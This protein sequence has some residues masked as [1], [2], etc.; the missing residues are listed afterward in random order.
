M[1]AAWGWLS[2]P[3]AD[4][5]CVTLLHFLWQGALCS[6]LGWT[7]IQCFAANSS[8]RRYGVWLT[9]LLLMALLPIATLWWTAPRLGESAHFAVHTDGQWIDATPVLASESSVWMT[10]E[11]DAIADSA[12]FATLPSA[13]DLRRWQPYLLLGWLM[14]VAVTSLRVIFGAVW[15]VRL[16]QNLERWPERWTAIAERLSR[17]LGLRAVPRLGLSHAVSSP[18]AVWLWRPAV[19]LPASWLTDSPPEM[20]EA[21]IAHELAHIRRHDLW[22][23]LLQRVIETLL[24]FHPCV[25]WVSRQI[26]HERELCCDAL[27]VTATG[28][29]ADY[30]RALEWV[31]TWR[32]ASAGPLL[33]TGLGGTRM[34]LLQRVKRVL[35]MESAAAD[36]G[37][38]M[39]GATGLG[40]LA[41]CA[42]VLALWTAP[43]QGEDETPS[44][45]AAENATIDDL[46]NAVGR[47]VAQRDEERDP[48]RRSEGARE[49][50]RR[51]DGPRE[52]D[53]R[54]DGPRDGER[55]P[56]GP[57]DGERRPEGPRDGERPRP[58]GPRD[59][60]RPRP[61]GAPRD[62]DR[63][64]DAPREVGPRG[65][66]PEGD[67]RGPPV[68]EMMRA[69]R[70]LRE[71]VAALRRE[72]NEMRSQ[73]QGPPF[74]RD[75]GPREGGPRPEF[76]DGPP[77]PRE[78]G[79]RPEFR[80]GPPGP[81]GRGEGRPP[82]EGRPQPPR[83]GEPRPDRERPREDRD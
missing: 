68:D 24:F 26:R 1:I 58:D 13:A 27:A 51:P 30:A 4:A 71:E 64:P 80:D 28:R 10:W 29:A 82:A 20:L 14:G 74:L 69:I 54:P 60:E 53:R 57:R 23:N 33:G 39:W 55:R 21:V 67:F 49:G 6:L 52:G 40:A 32:L 46:V 83:E 38:W 77:G 47:A 16:H 61:E 37:S 19:I 12:W 31:A 48:P 5:L 76:R 70:E 36:S 7:A 8:T 65:P 3:W 50:D 35:G 72:L 75:G 11:S 18:L 79:P 9:V 78:G 73:R 45:A 56:D 17:R 63:R 81:R 41:V 43:V 25:W 22:I 42:L 62:G 15:I 66:R 59:G 34:V 2:G 44:A